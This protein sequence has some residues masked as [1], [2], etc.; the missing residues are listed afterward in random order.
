M[1]CHNN[2]RSFWW[3]SNQIRS[4]ALW[5]HRRRPCPWIRTCCGDLCSMRL[6][7]VGGV[8]NITQWMNSGHYSL[9]SPCPLSLGLFGST[10]AGVRHL[11]ALCHV[12]RHFNTP[13]WLTLA[14]PVIAGELATVIATN[15][16]RQCPSSSP[17]VARLLQIHWPPLRG[18][19]NWARHELR[20]VITHP[21]H[22]HLPPI[23]HQRPR[24]AHFPQIGFLPPWKGP[25]R[26]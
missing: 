24:I 21:K 13:P 11:A 7:N 20:R 23:V 3:Y 18:P 15:R 9:R 2:W 10:L 5:T 4:P 14:H 25:R 19:I 22:H 8:R 6:D 26:G 17:A 16:A 12:P 1:L